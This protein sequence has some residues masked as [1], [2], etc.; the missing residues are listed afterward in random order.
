[1]CIH[2]STVLRLRSGR[3]ERSIPCTIFIAM[4][5]SSG[6]LKCIHHGSGPAETSFQHYLVYSLVPTSTMSTVLKDVDDR[7]KSKNLFG[8]I[9]VHPSDNTDLLDN[10]VDID[11]PYPFLV[12]VVSHSNGQPVLD[13]LQKQEPGE[14]SVRVDVESSVDDPTVRAVGHSSAGTAETRQSKS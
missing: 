9:L 4:E 7:V 5:Q 1:M 3:Q 2:S 13:W 12:S 14:V 11:L 10:F 8:L 6:W